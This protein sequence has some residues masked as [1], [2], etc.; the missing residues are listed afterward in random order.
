M[1]SKEP[2]Q[3]LP[4]PKRRQELKQKPDTKWE[5]QAAHPTRLSLT[6][7]PV[8]DSELGEESRVNLNYLENTDRWLEM[9]LTESSITVTLTVPSF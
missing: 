1:S 2:R 5:A 6:V 8:V 4:G 7:S 3:L 9:L